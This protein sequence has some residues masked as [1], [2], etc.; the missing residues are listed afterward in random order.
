MTKIPELTTHAKQ[1]WKE[2]FS[3]LCFEDEWESARRPGK[4]VRKNIKKQCPVN[5]PIM[6]RDNIERMC[7]ISDNDVVFIYNA[8]GIVITVFPYNRGI[9]K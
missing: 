6:T 9:K 3:N 1:R 7:L 8:K 5:A 2:R 4:S